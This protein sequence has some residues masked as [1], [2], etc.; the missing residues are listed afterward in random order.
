[1]KIAFSI[2]LALFFTFQLSAQS[3]KAEKAKGYLKD[4]MMASSAMDEESAIKYYKK[5]VKTDPRT[6]RTKQKS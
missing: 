1:M 4:G 3:K 6:I 5:A 2:I